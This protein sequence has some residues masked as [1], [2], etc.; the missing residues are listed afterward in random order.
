MAN[1]L[2]DDEIAY[3]YDS[4]STEKDLMGEP[5]VHSRLIFYLIDVLTSLFS[6]QTCSVL[7]NLNFYQTS[8]PNEYPLEPDIAVIRGIE[9]GHVRSWR[10]GKSGP[11]P[12]VIL[13]IGAEET[14]KKDL[15]EKPM[16]YMLMGVQEYFAYDPN[17]PSLNRRTSQRLFGWDLDKSQGAIY[18]MPPGPDGRLWSRHL[19]SFLVPDNDY[20][21]LQVGVGQL[22][23]TRAEAMER[24]AEAEAQRADTEKQRA[25]ALA[26]KLRAL[27]IDPDQI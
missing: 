4:H 11:A 14:W 27:G 1:R 10:V 22:R 24:L 8:D 2:E 23:L 26:E 20:L 3:Y 5:S 9:C 17:I 18:E 21:R 12:Q 6:A 13:E 15:E 19:E 25:D 7:K 16:Q